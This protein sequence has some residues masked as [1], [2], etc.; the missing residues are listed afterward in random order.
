MEE[1][2]CKGREGLDGGWIYLM[3]VSNHDHSLQTIVAI[4]RILHRQRKERSLYDEERGEERERRRGACM[5]R[6]GGRRGKEGER[7][8]ERGEGEGGGEGRKE[9]GGRRG[10]EG[11]PEVGR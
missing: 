6:R 7:G 10:K 4:F 3:M 8:E 1:A 5:M 11:E 9:R 2:M